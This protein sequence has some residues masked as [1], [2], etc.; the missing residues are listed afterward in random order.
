MIIPKKV[1]HKRQIAFCAFHNRCIVVNVAL[2]VLS[3][4]ARD[5]LQSFLVFVIEKVL[6]YKAEYFFLNK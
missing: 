3:H 2:T 6:I 1:G 5:L 4:E